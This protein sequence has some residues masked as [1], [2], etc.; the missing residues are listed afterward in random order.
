MGLLSGKAAG[1]VRVG[2]AAAALLGV[3]IVAMMAPY[4]GTA[5]GVLVKVVADSV[6]V[7]RGGSSFAPISASTTLEAGQ[8]LRTD[9]HGRALLTYF[10]GTTVLIGEDSE[11]SYVVSQ[12]SLGE[13][14]VTM[15]Q[16]AGRMW[17]RVSRALSPGSR[18]E[19]H[20]PVGAAVVRAGSAMDATVGDDGATTVVATEGSVDV[21]SGGTSVPLRPGQQTVVKRGAPPSSPSLSPQADA[22]SPAPTSSPTATAGPPSTP[23]PTPSSPS[24]PI[25]LP[26]IVPTPTPVPTLTGS[27]SPSPSPLPLPSPSLSPSTSPLPTSNPV[28]SI[29]PSLSAP[30]LPSPTLPSLP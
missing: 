23:Q 15:L 5:P 19:V 6:L 25:V 9:H 11:F 22:A 17:Y 24:A 14:V 13:I 20:F 1:V 18:Y 29:V 30:P 8:S 7:N 21:S 4:R 10:D 28:S 3:G 26:S 2:V 27:P 16:S 12:T